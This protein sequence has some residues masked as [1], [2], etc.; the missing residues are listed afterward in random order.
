[1]PS[2][3]SGNPSITLDCGSSAQGDDKTFQVNSASTWTIKNFTA[4]TAGKFMRQN[5]DTTF[6]MTVNIDHCDIADMGEC[7]YRT[8]SSS[9]IVNMTNTRYHN[10]GD[11][12]IFG[13]SKV[14]G[15]THNQ[16]GT[17]SGNQSY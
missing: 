10:V 8:D 9:S 6:K 4:K 7:I 14:N 15:D 12:F 3:V 2:G 1:M 5:G 11:L 13:S 17:F 16:V